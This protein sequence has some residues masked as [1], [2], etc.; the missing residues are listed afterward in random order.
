M[1]GHVVLEF[2]INYSILTEMT[3]KNIAFV[4][5]IWLNA[6]FFYKIITVICRK[7]LY[8]RGKLDKK[9]EIYYNSY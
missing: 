2:V 6:I 5:S 8:R 1:N 7:C 9:K 4:K 3:K